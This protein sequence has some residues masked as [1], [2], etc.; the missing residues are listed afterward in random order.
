MTDISWADALDRLI[1]LFQVRKTARKE[2]LEAE[3]SSFIDE[4]L[5]VQTFFI[6]GLEGLRKR[7]A[8]HAKRAEKLLQRNDSAEEMHAISADLDALITATD[9]KRH[10]RRAERMALSRIA[11]SRTKK[12]YFE[13]SVFQMITDDERAAFRDFYE[14]VC[15]N[16]SYP[17]LLY[18][19]ELSAGLRVAQ[20]GLDRISRLPLHLTEEQKHELLGTLVDTQKRLE[21]SRDIVQERYAE[22]KALHDRIRSSLQ[23]L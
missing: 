15:E 13:N 16:F 10:F 14:A 17:D 8:Y 12:E 4:F 20:A 23:S 7:F 19:H 6:E 5:E 18:Y 21:G 11:E 22:A 3:F 9:D 1:K 2:L